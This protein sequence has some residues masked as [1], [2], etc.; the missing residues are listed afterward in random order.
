[1]LF[2]F[3]SIRPN[4]GAHLFRL[5]WLPIQNHS[6][7]RFV[8][9]YG[10]GL[11]SKRSTVLWGKFFYALRTRILITAGRQA[12]TARVNN[13]FIFNFQESRTMSV[14]ADTFDLTKM[15]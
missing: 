2:L 8:L 14:T 11:I 7:G 12:D 10:S 15:D 6:Q 3:L 13:D 1:M 5:F 4:Q 9:S